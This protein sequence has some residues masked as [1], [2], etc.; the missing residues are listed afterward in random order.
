M[1]PLHHSIPSSLHLSTLQSESKKGKINECQSC[2]VTVNVN[3]ASEDAPLLTNCW[4]LD[5]RKADGTCRDDPLHIHTCHSCLSQTFERMT[6]GHEER[7]IETRQR[8][9]GQT[10]V[11]RGVRV[12]AYLLN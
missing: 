1:V 8:R 12:S 9:K 3:G 5:L 2:G 11:R 4:I 6:G 10:R 7:V